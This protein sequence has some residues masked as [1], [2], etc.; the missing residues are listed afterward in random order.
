VPIYGGFPS[1]G[2]QRN[3]STSSPSRAKSRDWLTN[4]TILKGGVLAQDVNAATILDGLIIQ[5]GRYGIE[6]RGNPGPSIINCK[7]EDNYDCGIYCDNSHPKITNCVIANNGNRDSF[8]HGGGIY[9]NN[10]SPTITNCI[11]SGNL[12]VGKD[13]QYGQK[14]G[15]MFNSASS[16]TITNCIFTGNHAYIGGGI[17]NEIYSLPIVTN[18]TFIGNE[19]CYGGGGMCN[20]YNSSPAVTNCIFWGNKANSDGNEVYN[21][22]DGSDPNF[23][24]CDIEDCGAPDNWD[25]DLGTDGGNNINADPCFYNVDDPN[26]YHLT[27]DSNCIDAGDPNFITNPDETDIDGEDRKIDGDANGTVIVDMGADEYY[28]SPADFDE[29]EFVNFIDYAKFAAAWQTENA[30][31]SL[32]DDNYVDYNDLALFCKDWLWIAG[33]LKTFGYG[34]CSMGS[35]TGQSLGLTEGASLSAP[36]EQQQT[37]ETTQLDIEELLKWLDELWL[38]PEVRE[39]ITEEQWLEFTESIKS[40][41]K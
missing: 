36:A 6:C 38:M 4:E 13:I 41:L 17:Y 30:D 25:T 27:A 23:S 32:D 2:G 33:W 18:C 39:V 31:I 28:W 12:A 29:D 15:A 16:P 26:S 19:A 37:E 22:D 20:E 9:C 5:N 24:Y 3:G 10:S 1:G 8:L 14:G 11:F 7:I 35:G 21:Y 34:M 40:E